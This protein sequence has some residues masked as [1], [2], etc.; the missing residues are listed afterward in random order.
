MLYALGDLHLASAS[1]KPMDVF[2]DKWRDHAAR[3][4]DHWQQIV[5]DEDVVLVP[6]DISW[7]MTLPEAAL[8]LAYLGNLPGQKVLIRGNHDYWWNGIGK[9]RKAL[10]SGLYALQNDAL[11]LADITLCG[12]RGWLLPTHP[13]FT[14]EDWRLYE[15]EAHRL[16]MSLEAATRLGGPLVCMI[17][18]PPL[19]P[20][21][22]STLF[23]DLLETYRVS[24]CVY[25][26]LHGH[27][28]VHRCPPERSGVRYQLVSADFVDFRPVPVDWPGNGTDG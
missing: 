22:G 14:E 9:V 5:R 17:H 12:T 25:G 7:A 28:H 15:R 19:G 23:T 27:A 26:H 4:R 21:G 16:R 18:Y 3:I 11:R 24:V 13:Q 2:G 20:D 6:G 10:P 1:A 8:D